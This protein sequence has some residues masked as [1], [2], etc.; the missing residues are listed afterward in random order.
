MDNLFTFFVSFSCLILFINYS[1]SHPLCI[2]Q[3]APLALSNPLAFCDQYSGNVCCNS[4]DDFQLQNQFKAMNISDSTCGSVIKSVICSRCDQFSAELYRTRSVPFLCNSS[5]SV[6]ST[7]SN[8]AAVSFCS[9]LWDVC[10]NESISH[11]PFVLGGQLND[12]TSKLS[13]LFQ[14]KTA[15]CDAFGGSSDD[16][17]VCFTGAPVLLNSSET[18]T[19]PSGICLEKLDNGMYLNMVGHPDGSNRVFLSSQQGTIWLATI[20]SGGTGETLVRNE[21]SPYLDLTDRV[22][23]VNEFGLM[24]V[25]FHPNFEQ[26]G[27]LF[28]SFN[29]DKA[30]WPECSGIC[31]CNL[32][33]GC[34]PSKL[35]PDN[36]AK[37]CQYHSVIAEFTANG[38]IS[39]VVPREVN[40]IFT[41]GLPFT[42]HHGGQILFG[43]EDGYLYFMMGDGGGT[44]D[45]Y[46][47]S[48]N[49]KSLLGKIL[50]LDINRVTTSNN[51]SVWGNYS[52]PG[53]NPFS[54]DNDLQP[55]IWASG[56]RNPW[57]C[58]FD[59]ERDS[60]FLCADVGQDRYEEVDIVTK[61]GNYGWRVYEGRLLYNS[62]NPYIP[63]NTI[64][65]VLGYNRTD[66]NSTGGSAS[67]TG[68]YFYRS[69]TDPCMYGRYLYA[70]LYA[71]TIW[72][73]TESPRGSGNFTSTKLPIGCAKDSPIQCDTLPG[74]ST[75]KLEYVFSF[76]QDNTKDAYVLA[77]SG[78]YR[79]VR[80]SR[81]NFTCSKENVTD[82]TNQGGSVPSRAA[83]SSLLTRRWFSN[84]LL[85]YVV[86][87]I[88]L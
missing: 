2:N 86:L 38:S 49:K 3:R 40:R 39:N 34:D 42:S 28:V 88:F 45:P 26:N 67:I 31:S 32:N 69:T 68:G 7:Q 56:F 62:S 63:N 22:Y 18:L 51:V 66:I 12:S 13:D 11:S 77:S 35:T 29:C 20:P 85:F 65:P 50:R 52:I 41:M 47:F 21:S 84:F 75:P 55:E 80:P 5:V 81:C 36:G 23:S 43:P 54:E 37:P 78:L 53:D 1:S 30:K 71:D 46:N 6:N 48:Q 4:T 10:E 25:A 72:A 24:G 8:L 64:F 87:G 33:V 82:T 76:G 17:A 58:S 74:T 70:D 60:Y 83:S 9:K 61:G 19:P 57:R 15:F 16:G 44:G 73:G 14:S 27:R 79:V 59:A